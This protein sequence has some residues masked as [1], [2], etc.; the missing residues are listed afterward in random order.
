VLFAAFFGTL[1]V[2]KVVAALDEVNVEEVLSS[3]VGEL[4][5]TMTGGS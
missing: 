3:V 2:G 5:H 4:C 1:V